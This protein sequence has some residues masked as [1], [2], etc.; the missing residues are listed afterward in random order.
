MENPT[1]PP[2]RAIKN[3]AP[4]QPVDHWAVRIA[5][6]AVEWL[7]AFGG[8]LAFGVMVALFVVGFWA[9]IQPLRFAPPFGHRTAAP[10]ITKADASAAP[11]IN[12]KSAPIVSA[13][14]VAKNEGVAESVQITIHILEGV[15]LLLLAPLP[16]LVFVSLSRYVRDFIQTDLSAIAALPPHTSGA[17]FHEI[18]VLIVSLMTAS[19]ATDLM[20][21]AFNSID[22]N[23]ALAEGLVML[24]L[25]LYWW[26]LARQHR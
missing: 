8:T 20:R 10:A 1:I 9:V 5:V 7:P 12:D 16:F 14:P 11:M 18:K 15:E 2:V 4:D 22:L 13:M 25:G 21:R 19:V 3:K 6:D 26:A 24:L 23:V 17:E